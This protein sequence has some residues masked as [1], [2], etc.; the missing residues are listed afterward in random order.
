MG[1]AYH[2]PPEVDELEDG[3]LSSEDGLAWSENQAYA[4]SS[5]TWTPLSGLSSPVEGGFRTSEG[6]LVR[7]EDDGFGFW[8][9]GDR[10]WTWWQDASELSIS[11]THPPIGDQFVA[12]EQQGFDDR[13]LLIYSVSPAGLEHRAAVDD[14]P[15]LP[16][17]LEFAFVYTPPADA[18]A[19]ADPSPHLVLLSG[20]T[21]RWRPLSGNAESFRTTHLSLEQEARWLTDQFPP[22]IGGILSEYPPQMHG[23]TLFLHRGSTSSRSTLAI[24][25]GDG[26]VA[27]T[28]LVPL[29]RSSAPWQAYADNCPDEIAPLINTLH[30]CP[31][32]SDDRHA[33]TVELL[34]VA[35]GEQT[36][37]AVLTDHGICTGD[38]LPSPS[39]PDTSTSVES[40][41]NIWIWWTDSLLSWRLWVGEDRAEQTL[42]RKL[43]SEITDEALYVEPLQVQIGIEAC[44]RFFDELRGED[45][46]RSMLGDFDYS[47]DAIRALFGPHG[48]EVAHLVE[49]GLADEH[50]P[51]RAAACMAAGAREGDDHSILA[52]LDREPIPN[53]RLWPDR[54]ALPREA[55]WD[56]L[57]HEAPEVRRAAAKTCGLLRLAGSADSLQPLLHDTPLLDDDVEDVRET[58]LKALRLVPE[59][60]DSGV[61]DIEACVRA[62]P[63]ASVRQTAVKTLGPHCRGAS[64][65]EA[66]I[67]SLGDTARG[68]GDYVSDALLEHATD[69][70]PEQYRKLIDRW[71]L[72]YLGHRRNDDVTTFGV[73]FPEQLPGQVLGQRVI[74][75]DI[76]DFRSP[77]HSPEDLTIE[78]LSITDETVQIAPA[79]ISI[80]TILEAVVEEV[81]LS[82]SFGESSSDRE[83]MS[84][85]EQAFQEHLVAE[86]FL[87]EIDMSNWNYPAP[88]MQAAECAAA[89]YERDARLGRRLAAVVLS[90]LGLP[91]EKQT[92]G[93]AGD[94]RPMHARLRDYSGASPHEQCHR[95]VQEL[96]ETNGASGL[97]GLYVLAAAGDDEAEAS[98]V[99]QFTTGALTDVP[100][101]RL[102]LQSTTPFSTRSE[103]FVEGTLLGPYISTDDIPLARRWE[104]FQDQHHMF[105]SFPVETDHVSPEQWN[106]F[107]RQCAAADELLYWNDRHGAALHLAWLDDQYERP[108]ELWD[109]RASSIEAVSE[110]EQP[111]YVRDQI[112]AG[113]SDDWAAFWAHWPDGYGYW[114][115]RMLADWGDAEAANRVQAALK[116]ES[117][118]LKP[119][120]DALQAIEARTES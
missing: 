35:M 27:A 32:P 28:G 40:E 83:E 51:V 48:S 13:R 84:E 47:D 86:T 69:V 23:D 98:L 80:L 31:P 74:A 87:D 37:H 57:S 52:I 68:V 113:Q 105:K 4:W 42:Y 76:Q 7:T 72:R 110:G 15:D 34:D 2:L 89:V 45:P 91:Y 21:L 97:L 36:V 55:L 116:G 1:A 67:W 93:A 70:T 63:S 46:P 61:Q 26:T 82:S 118:P 107:F 90:E 75:G 114:A 16:E 115:L 10:E 77:I 20:E 78:D 9:F 30:T 112:W 3:V 104:A 85:F 49:S 94:Y 108:A 99:E 95:Y 38:T 73:S 8:T 43:A 96:A 102:L 39:A 24:D 58:V 71:L 12:E 53:S 109:E 19:S 29:G 64:S 66:L 103:A 119:A 33:D 60:P 120:T 117:I 81:L 54:A 22:T 6:V 14:V 62:D 56:N 50:T 18:G 17:P 11:N 44:R 79:A 88:S 65:L 59:V 92:S 41:D 25:L 100:L 111:G 106:F 101:A 5:G